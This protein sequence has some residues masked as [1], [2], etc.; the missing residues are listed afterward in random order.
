MNKKG[1]VILLLTIMLLI[2]TAAIIVII[3]PR[4]HCII[5]GELTVPG[6]LKSIYAAEATWRQVDPENNGLNDY[7]T[8]DISGLY[9]ILRRN[10]PAAFITLYLAEADY[11]PAFD[12]VFGNYPILENWAQAAIKP[13]PLYGYYYQA[14]LFDEE[15]NLYN[16]NQV[17]DN[18][19]KAANSSKFAFTAYP[20][21]YGTPYCYSIF[22]INEKGIIYATDC[23]SDDAKIVLKWPGKDPTTVKG[24]G[25]K[26]WMPTGN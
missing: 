13:K 20:E 22:I 21:K 14:M 16:Q 18:K 1:I 12:A 19:I 8:Y 17:G 15:G 3:T 25:G 6:M 5:A 4:R 2:I 7:W 26:Y 23:G 24:P 9:R 10:E 11:K